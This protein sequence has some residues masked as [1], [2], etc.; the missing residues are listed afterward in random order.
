[1]TEASTE[2]SV[3]GAGTEH[4]STPGITTQKMKL[5]VSDLEENDL[6][7]ISV[8]VLFERSFCI[9]VC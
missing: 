4:M 8:F 2:V 7:Y 5:A 9:A 1:M 6:V 3:S